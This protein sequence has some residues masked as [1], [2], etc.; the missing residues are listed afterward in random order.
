M[1]STK[2]IILMFIL[3]LL[4]T[5]IQKLSRK[6]IDARAATGLNRLNEDLQDVTRIMTKNMEDLLYRGES[7]DSCV[8]YRLLRFFFQLMIPQLWKS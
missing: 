1:L 2:L 5:Y 6:Y 7:L 8:S 4:D 3:F